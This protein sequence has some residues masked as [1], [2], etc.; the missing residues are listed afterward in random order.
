MRT[1]GYPTSPLGI[2]VAAVTA[3]SEDPP[4]AELDDDPFDTS[5]RYT[6][7]QLST[8]PY[9]FRVTL[10]AN[11]PASDGLLLLASRQSPWTTEIPTEYIPPRLPEDLKPRLLHQTPTI[12]RTDNLLPKPARDPCYIYSP[13]FAGLSPTECL[14]HFRGSIIFTLYKPHI[15]GI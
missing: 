2:Q 7:P 1:A 4:T 14:H 3:I 13:A 6:P 15:L 9:K 12:T 8:Y 10:P 5:T 11:S